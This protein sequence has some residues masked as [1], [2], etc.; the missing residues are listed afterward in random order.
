M[1]ESTM[2]LSTTALPSKI[3]S[4]TQSAV[5]GNDHHSLSSMIDFSTSCGSSMMD[6]LP[7][8]TVK[9]HLL[10]P[11]HYSAMNHGRPQEHVDLVNQMPRNSAEDF[12]DSSWRPSS[13]NRMSSNSSSSSDLEYL[14]LKSEPDSSEYL[15]SFQGPKSD[16]HGL[17]SPLNAFKDEL[18]ASETEPD[19]SS[20][21]AT[22]T[23]LTLTSSATDW[24]GN[25]LKY[26]P[27]AV[28]TGKS[29]GMHYGCFTCEA[30]KNFFRR[31]LLRNSGFLC[32]KNNNCPIL[33]RSRGN[34][35]GCRLQKCLEVGMAKEKSKIG[36]YTH[37]Q[38]TETIRKMN[39]LEGKDD[40]LEMGEP[41]PNENIKMEHFCEEPAVKHESLLTEDEIE[42]IKTLVESMDAIQHFGERGSTPEGRE[43]II[44]EHYDR[45]QAKVKLFGPLRAIPKDEYF[46]LLKMHNIDLDGRWNLFK[47]EANNCSHIVTRYCQFAYK[48]PGFSELSMKDQENLL[49][50]GHCDFFTILLHEGYDKK[51]GIF[52][53]M[54]GV[55]AHI[56][57][58]AD[59]IFSREI[60]ELQCEISTRWQG[61]VLQKEEKAL[62][63]AMALLCS[64][65]IDLEHP[66]QVA[67]YNDRL[68]ELLLKVMGTVHGKD[69]QKRFTK[70]IDILTFSREASHAYFREYQQM[71]NN[72][73]V[74]SAAPK[75]PSL[76]PETF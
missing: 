14:L 54:N 4:L 48:I 53:E 33:N 49:K 6:T 37:V 24:K 76:C 74:T 52:L 68:M 59:K 8:S 17:S 63:I 47:Q 26:P 16:K 3:N 42:L 34:C 71:S 60:V 66:D 73:M 55:P 38:R 21:I 27:C 2:D 45:Y 50:I 64:D 5:N 19:S 9:E 30:C 10:N 41:T 20:S 18:F 7:Q 65:R 58:A 36:R 44:S 35:S 70:F 67:T 11:I 40:S 72:E 12:H 43:A 57:E 31:Y 69:T 28:C 25:A 13:V 51:R 62:L 29:S 15:L 46:T 23:D 32:K 56:E 22:D 61:L 75:F 39:R 1:N